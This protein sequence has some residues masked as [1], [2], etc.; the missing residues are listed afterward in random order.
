MASSALPQVDAA[1]RVETGPGVTE[2][3]VRVARHRPVRRVE[4]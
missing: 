2:G 1:G 3:P 4:V